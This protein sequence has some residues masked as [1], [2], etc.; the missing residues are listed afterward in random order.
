MAKRRKNWRSWR[1]ELRTIYLG[2]T[3]HRAPETALEVACLGVSRFTGP[4]RRIVTEV[5]MEGEFMILML[6]GSYYFRPDDGGRRR[7]VHARAG[8]VVY[9]PKGSMRYDYNDPDDPMRVI[10]VNLNWPNPIANLPYMV[11]DQRRLITT[12][13]Q[14]IF[15]AQDG[16]I[17]RRH[18]LLDGYMSAIL[19]EYVRLADPGAESEL[20]AK[21]VRYTHEHLRRRI[22]LG[23]LARHVGLKRQYFGRRYKALTGRTPMQEVRRI[24]IEAAVG[25]LRILPDVPLKAIA[26][27][28]GL[29]NSHVLSRALK[30]DVNMT[31]REIRA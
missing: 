14:G 13:A 5:R 29:A 30:R 27:R 17:T 11:H 9:W 25:I 18:A 26:Y 16:S 28:L 21:V 15:L 22:A 7:I 4:S 19:A 8:D 20:V 2:G 12:I 10:C 3:L 23:D 24:R 6:G 1:K 31:S